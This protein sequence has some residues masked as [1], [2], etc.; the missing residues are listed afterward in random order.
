[1][2]DDP[3]ILSIKPKGDKSEDQQIDEVEVEQNNQNTDRNAKLKNFT[4]K[5]PKTESFNK[6]KF[7]M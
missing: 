5:L 3:L 6:S 4:E 2:N 1:M 7:I